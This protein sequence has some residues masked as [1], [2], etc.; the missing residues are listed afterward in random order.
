MG[1]AKIK[2]GKKVDVLSADGKVSTLSGNHIIIATGSRSRQL[3]NI[4]QD[5]K[6]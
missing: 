1:T 4:I 3:P 5:G 6:K 2:T